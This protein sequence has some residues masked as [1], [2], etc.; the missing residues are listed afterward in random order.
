MNSESFI[1]LTLVTEAAL[2]SSISEAVM[3]LGAR[4]YTITDA[5]GRGAHGVRSGDWGQ[6]NNIRLEVIGG[7]ELI[8]RIIDH[9]R[10]NYD[11]N[12]GLLMFTTPVQIHSR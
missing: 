5:R 7:S 8:Q 11:Q 10:E 2:E 6:G 12:Y 3:R 1:L 4:G 9:L